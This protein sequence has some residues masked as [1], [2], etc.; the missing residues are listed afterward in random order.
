MAAGT[1]IITYTVIGSGGCI[2]TTTLIV[3]VTAAPNAGTVSGTQAICSNGTTTFTSNGSSGGTWTSSDTAIATINASTGVITPVAAGTS[4]IS[5]AVG[6]G[7]CNTSAT[8]TVTVTA[9]PN[10][11]TISGT[12]ALC[13]ND[14]TTFTS[15]GTSGG[16]WTSSDTA[17][18]TIASTGVITPL[19]AGTSVCG[20]LLCWCSSPSPF[21]RTS[22]SRH[23]LAQPVLFVNVRDSVAPA[24]LGRLFDLKKS[25][26]SQTGISFPYSQ[27]RHPALH[28]PT[29]SRCASP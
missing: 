20:P 28:P 9:G 23:S 12:Q 7:G 15:N 22:R 14:T 8:R 10:A 29:P 1:S 25:L 21:E 2:N 4:T 27:Y 19:A 13:S 5:Y 16:T 24:V 18:A 26:E 3:T 6:L 17:K 11:G